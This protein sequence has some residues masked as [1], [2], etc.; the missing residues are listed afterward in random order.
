MYVVCTFKFYLQIF[1][2]TEKF[3][4]SYKSFLDKVPHISVGMPSFQT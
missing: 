4:L 2:I 1:I 3:E